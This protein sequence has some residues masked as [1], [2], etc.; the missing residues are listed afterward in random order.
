MK[1]IN[2]S[3][4]VN[5]RLFWQKSNKSWKM[6]KILPKNSSFQI[7]PILIHMSPSWGGVSEN[8]NIFQNSTPYAVKWGPVF[9][10]VSLPQILILVVLKLHH[11]SDFSSGASCIT[12]STNVVCRARSGLS[13][14][15]LIVS[16]RFLWE[17]LWKK[18]TFQIWSFF[19]FFGKNRKNRQKSWKFCRKT[20]V[21]RF[22]RFSSICSRHGAM[23]QK[24]WKFFKI[25]PHMRK[26]EG[27]FFTWSL[28]H[29]YSF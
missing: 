22:H 11:L 2:F 26:N 21:F 29:K 19:D 14:P 4:L 8:M 5:F 16:I 28:C 20:R 18:S 27:Q 15:C 1:K 13:A 7:L 12:K 24:I 3:N 25:R 6:V 17:K 9:H 10:M 23:F